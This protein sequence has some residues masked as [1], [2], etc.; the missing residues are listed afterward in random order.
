MLDEK[1]KTTKTMV[2]EMKKTLASFSEKR[3]YNNV[4]WLIR[5]ETNKN[6]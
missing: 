5:H 4:K 6:C 3:S 2:D 1:V